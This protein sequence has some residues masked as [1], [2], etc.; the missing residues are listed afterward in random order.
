MSIQ[1]TIEEEKEFALVSLFAV[2]QTKDPDKVKREATASILKT[3]TERIHSQST[4]LVRE[5][6]AGEIEKLKFYVEFPNGVSVKVPS[7]EP[8]LL[9]P[10]RLVNDI[11]STLSTPPERKE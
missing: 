10:T 9:I 7:S 5:E 1:K 2:Y 3:F 4:A 11:L 8:M 6:V